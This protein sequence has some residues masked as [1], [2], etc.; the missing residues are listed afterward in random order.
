MFKIMAS[1]FSN[2]NGRAFLLLLCNAAGR[3]GP[4]VRRNYVL[5]TSLLTRVALVMSLGYARLVP[6]FAWATI[7]Q[8]NATF[9]GINSVNETTRYPSTLTGIVNTGSAIGTWHSNDQVR[10]YP[11]PE[12]G[13]R[14]NKCCLRQN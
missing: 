9:R 12:G 11:G 7:F 10:R 3:R 6:H 14:K 8:G 5:A 13:G 2:Q 1:Q 4:K